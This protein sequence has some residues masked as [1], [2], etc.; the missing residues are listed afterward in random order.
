[1]NIG[2]IRENL[3]HK[4]TT[5]FV[6]NPKGEGYIYYASETS[7]GYSCTKQQVKSY[8]NDYDKSLKKNIRLFSLWIIGA[9]IS[10]AVLSGLEIYV[11]STIE[12]GIYFFIPAPFFIA[13]IRTVYNAPKALEIRKN[14]ATNLRSRQELIKSRIKG[15][16]PGMLYIVIFVSIFGIYQTI[17][18]TD[19][20]LNKALYIV[21]YSGVLILSSI[22]LYIQKKTK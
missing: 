15:I 4:Y 6:P 14:Q 19:P 20:T 13:K 2:L 16:N 9:V 12:M 8:I 10:M 17:T 3:V 7:N 18:D 11:L 5:K 21:C 1:M 22:I